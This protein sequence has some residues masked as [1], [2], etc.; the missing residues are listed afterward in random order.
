MAKPIFI[1]G[2]PAAADAQAIHQVYSDLDAK[3]GDEY[4][5]L[6]YRAQNIDDVKFEVLNAINA[7]D[8]EISE[9][10][11]KTREDID[12]ILKEKMLSELTDLAN[13]LNKNNPEEN[14]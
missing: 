7:T 10:I 1:V 13:E 6:T 11:A 5:V 14:V 8:I 9:L 3:L 2:F 12:I 4:H